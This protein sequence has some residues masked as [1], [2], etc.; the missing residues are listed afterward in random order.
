MDGEEITSQTGAL[1]FHNYYNLTDYNWMSFGGDM[2]Q[3]NVSYP[4]LHATL[5]DGKVDMNS[6][7]I[8]DNT[9]GELLVQIK[10]SS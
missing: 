6:F 1:K 2:N 7:R 10:H 3:E 8:T 9:T 4:D 5:L